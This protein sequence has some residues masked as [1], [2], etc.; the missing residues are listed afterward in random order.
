[1]VIPKLYKF[2]ETYSITGNGLDI[3]TFRK[4]V[5]D[6]AKIGMQ[7]VIC[8]S[9]GEAF[10]LTDDERVTLFKETRAALDEAGL[11]DTVVIAGT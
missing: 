6:L 11:L 1:M 3:S 4:H 8:G 5:V 7:P 10:Q 9:M 2:S